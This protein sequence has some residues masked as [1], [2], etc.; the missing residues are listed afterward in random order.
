VPCPRGQGPWRRPCQANTP[1]SPCVISST[2]CPA[3]LR[4]ISCKARTPRQLQPLSKFRL[5]AREC[6]Q[7]QP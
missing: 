3:K 1:T 2:V 4:A 6:S 7:K 5:A